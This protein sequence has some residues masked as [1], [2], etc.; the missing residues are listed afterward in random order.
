VLGRPGLR[1]SRLGDVV[2]RPALLHVFAD[3]AAKSLL[4]L[5]VRE[6]PAHL[7]NSGVNAAVAG[8][9]AVH[10]CEHFRVGGRRHG[11]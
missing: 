7:L 2:G 9:D 4:R 8:E 6:G 1:L 5:G 3:V 11:T 10:D